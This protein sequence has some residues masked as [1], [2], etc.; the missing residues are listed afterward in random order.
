[1]IPETPSYLLEYRKLLVQNFKEL[2]ATGVTGAALH[3]TVKEFWS[4][5]AKLQDTLGRRGAFEAIYTNP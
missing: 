1:M 4:V 2:Q 5:Q 3:A